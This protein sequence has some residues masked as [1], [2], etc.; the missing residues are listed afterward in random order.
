LHLGDLADG[1]AASDDPRVRQFRTGEL[2]G[3]AYG[4]TA[5]Q[6]YLKDLLL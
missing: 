5:P 1:L 2:D 3:P 4:T 6:D